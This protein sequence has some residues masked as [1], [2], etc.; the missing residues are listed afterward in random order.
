MVCE[1]EWFV[2]ESVFLGGVVCEGE[3]LV[4]NLFVSFYPCWMACD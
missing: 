3:W 1:R 2:R 4:S